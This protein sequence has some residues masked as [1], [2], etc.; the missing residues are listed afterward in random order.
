MRAKQDKIRKGIQFI[1]DEAPRGDFDS[2]QTEWLECELVDPESPI[3]D[4]RRELIGNVLKNQ[5]NKDQYAMKD[6]YYP[7]LIPDVREES[8]T[9]KKGVHTTMNDNKTT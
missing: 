2:E 1:K 7:L 3:H 9:R 5:K 6:Y 8:V 4:L